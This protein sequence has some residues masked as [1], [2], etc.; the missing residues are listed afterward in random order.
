[1]SLIFLGFGL[2]SPLWGRLSDVIG[3]RKKPLM[4]GPSLAGIV[5]LWIVFFSASS[6]TVLLYFALF[7]CGFFASA[8]VLVF[9]VGNDM[10][11]PGL[12]ATTVSFTNLLVMLGGMLLQPMV[13]KILDHRRYIGD[14]GIYVIDFQYALIILP[15]GLL[16]GGMLA[17]FLK[18]TY[19]LK[20]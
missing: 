10:C 8:Q 6:N 13:G 3:S 19:H 2:G 15:V 9:A 12:N 20:N 11:R 14:I 17:I 18:E 16:I 5:A 1:M 4:F 7:L